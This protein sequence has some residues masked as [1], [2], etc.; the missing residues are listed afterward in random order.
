MFIV[1][2]ILHQLKLP[3]A[4]SNKISL[5]YKSSTER[6]KASVYILDGSR[7]DWCYFLL[8]NAMKP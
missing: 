1:E 2:Y 3:N 5:S 8:D 6:L 4:N 7:K